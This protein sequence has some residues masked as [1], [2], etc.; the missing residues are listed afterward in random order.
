MKEYCQNATAFGEQ[1]LSV[2]AQPKHIT[3]IL[4]PR[5]KRSKCRK[6]FNEY[7]APILHC[8]GYKVS[9]IETESQGIFTVFLKL[10]QSITF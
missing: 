4:N 7:V 8:A 2:F 3:V 6:Y 5:S 10:D 1:R 9:I